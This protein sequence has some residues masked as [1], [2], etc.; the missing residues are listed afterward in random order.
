MNAHKFWQEKVCEEIFQSLTAQEMMV[1]V[2]IWCG[3]R[4]K[5]IADSMGRSQRTVRF[6][7]E[8]IFLKTGC[9][10]RVAIA[11]LVERARRPALS[12]LPANIF[13]FAVENWKSRRNKK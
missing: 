3:L 7:L 12:L 2:S 6:H 8:N 13:F 5:E 10:D 9:R 1:S 11:L 4:D